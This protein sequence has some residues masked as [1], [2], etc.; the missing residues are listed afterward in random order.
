MLVTYQ[1]R[2]L[3][4]VLFILILPPFPTMYVVRN[5]EDIWRG[6]CHRPKCVSLGRRGEKIYH[7]EG[8]DLPPHQTGRLIKQT[9]NII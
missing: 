1:K 8:L 7:E 9:N 4:I 3:Q 2:I 5:S 6:G